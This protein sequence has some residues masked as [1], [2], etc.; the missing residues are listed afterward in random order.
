MN[1]AQRQKEKRDY[2]D[3]EIM[4]MACCLQNTEYEFA[5]LPIKDIVKILNAELNRI[6]T[7][8]SKVGLSISNVSLSSKYDIVKNKILF[9][10]IIG[11]IR[12]REIIEAWV[13]VIYERCPMFFSEDSGFNKKEDLAKFVNQILEPDKQLILHK[14]IN[15]LRIFLNKLIPELEKI[16]KLRFRNDLYLIFDR[17]NMEINTF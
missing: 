16:K 15:N 14:D 5:D 4:K 12:L 11:R 6:Q 1:S 7:I 3:S 10:S 17:I 8:A 2:I 9:S 13:N